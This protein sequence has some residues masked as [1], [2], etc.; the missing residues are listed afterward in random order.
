MRRVSGWFLLIFGLLGFG[1]EIDELLSGTADKPVFG[2]ILATICVLG[3][4][5]LIRGAGRA[6]PSAGP[7]QAGAAARPTALSP[8]DVEQVVLSCAKRHGGRVTIA[9]VAA[10]TELSFTESK[11]VLEELAREGAC[12]VDVTEQG[13]FIYEFAGLLPRAPAHQANDA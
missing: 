6:T 4:G 2:F 3:G 5:A 11:K 1:V 10:D 9:E 8:R 13:A 12:T 7:A